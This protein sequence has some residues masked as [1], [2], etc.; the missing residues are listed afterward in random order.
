MKHFFHHSIVAL[1]RANTN[2][3]K[4]LTTGKHSQV[5]LMNVRP[6]EDIGSEVHDVDQTLIFV[7][8]EGIAELDGQKFSVADG[9]LV[10]VP[11]GTKHNFTNSG[12]SELKLYTIYA[13]PEHKPGAV[14]ATKADAT[15]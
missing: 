1:A 5:V 14:A 8:G 13:P 4:E 3:R 9:T 15:H 12:S 10:F 7:A 6:G 2:F 11:A